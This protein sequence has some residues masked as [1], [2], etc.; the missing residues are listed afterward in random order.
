MAARARLRARSALTFELIMS[1]SG[2]TETPGACGPQPAHCAINGTSAF[3]SRALVYDTAAGVFYGTITSSGCPSDSRAFTFDGIFSIRAGLAAPRCFSQRFPAPWLS[4]AVLPVS[5][6]ASSRTGL[7]LRGGEDLSG[8]Q[9]VAPL[10]GP[11][12]LAL[13]SGGGGACPAGADWSFCRADAERQCGSPALLADA[14]ISDCGGALAP[15]VGVGIWRYAAALTC[16]ASAAAAAPLAAN[17]SVAG[18]A[19]HSPLLAVMLDGRGLYG[20]WERS[21]GNTTA[22][23]PLILDACSGHTGLVPAAAAGVDMYP[24]AAGPVY[25]YHVQTA[26][27]FVPGC[28][29]PA[30]SLLQARALYPACAGAAAVAAAAINS[31]ADTGACAAPGGAGCSLGD[32]YSR[33][34]ALGAT[35]GGGYELG[36]PIFSQRYSPGAAPVLYNQLAATGGC[37]V[38]TGF[39]PRD[40]SRA[41]GSLGLSQTGVTLLVVGMLVAALS[42]FAIWVYRELHNARPFTLAYLV[43]IL[44]G[45][46]CGRCAAAAVLCGARCNRFSAAAARCGTGCC[47]CCTRGPVTASSARK[48]AISRVVS[49]RPSSVSKLTR[50]R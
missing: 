37:S 13:C 35:T 38:C 25:H 19:G 14:F 5:L 8:P 12:G 17:S 27:P 21:A 16:E 40:G 29:G 1:M 31:S 39:C 33:C 47:T 7:A 44:R 48:S 22:S 45:A 24:A 43:E 9:L 34:T 30:A 18:S 15:G 10:G 3:A 32:M 20:P 11:G 4:G 49:F 42:I 36:C 23:P 28:L 2:E 46:G 26:A 6:N 41:P 50:K